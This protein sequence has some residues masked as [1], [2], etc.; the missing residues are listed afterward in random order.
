MMPVGLK[1]QWI[2]YMI[3]ERVIKEAALVFIPGMRR[4]KRYLVSLYHSNG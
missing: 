3:R 2:F 1:M 4:K